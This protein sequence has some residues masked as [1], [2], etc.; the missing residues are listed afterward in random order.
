MERMER[1]K[2]E[3]ARQAGINQGTVIDAEKAGKFIG[4]PLEKSPTPYLR[5]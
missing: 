4:R 3:L 2:A 5:G 1:S